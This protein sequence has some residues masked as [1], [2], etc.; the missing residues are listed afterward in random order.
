ME[1]LTPLGLAVIQGHYEVTV[2]LA[3][4]G[5]NLEIEF[6]RVAMT[7][8][9]I[10]AFGGKMDI[11]AYLM[12]RMIGEGEK[13]REIP[14]FELLWD[15][16]SSNHVEVV[17][18]LLD[19]GANIKVGDEYY[20]TLVHKAVSIWDY[21]GSET[22]VLLIERGADL[23]AKDGFGATPLHIAVRLGLVDA[24]K[25]LLDNGADPNAE[26]EDGESPLD[27]VHLCENSYRSEISVS[28]NQ[29]RERFSAQRVE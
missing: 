17:R 4:S 21:A 5:A 25:M 19:E 27:L 16:V 26:N 15:A 2:L 13:L 9:Q 7:P 20:C 8:L 1:E 3:E 24:V 6:P 12:R 14:F 11:M 28:L 10:A 22:A 29:A 23:S 18:F